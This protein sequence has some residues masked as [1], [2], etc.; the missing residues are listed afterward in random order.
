MQGWFVATVGAVA[1]VLSGAGLLLDAVRPGPFDVELA[2]AQVPVQA[3]GSYSARSGSDVPLGICVQPPCEP[4][5]R[6]ELHLAGLPA[7]R[8][9]A[10]LEGVRVVDLGAFVASPSGQSLLWER[11]EDH[12]D[13][14]RLVL[15]H[16]GLPLHAW[17]VR[18][19]EMSLA[20]PAQASF[21]FAPIRVHLDEIGAVSVS[22]TAKSMLTLQ[23]PAG[24][25]FVA[26][27]ESG[28]SSVEMGAFERKDE[29]LVLDGRVERVRLGDQERVTVY[30]V[31]ADTQ[32]GPGV[33]VWSAPL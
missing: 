19:G 33:P 18:A 31:G 1:I 7:G 8:Y 11:A 27:L 26:R 23:A 16:A 29:A 25:S 10:R 21:G 12:T 32:G 13:K 17:D 24:T 15:L 22:T 30:L 3:T 4:F 14:S 20:G 5:T 28:V 2:A 9:E 6:V